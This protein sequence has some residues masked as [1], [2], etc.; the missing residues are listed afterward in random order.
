[1]ALQW[2]LSHLPY[3]RHGKDLLTY[4]HRD[5]SGRCVHTSPTGQEKVAGVQG[6]MGTEAGA[7]S[8]W[9]Q[10]TVALLSSRL[11]A[12]DRVCLVLAGFS[13]APT[14]D[15]SRL[16]KMQQ[17]RRVRICNTDYEHTDVSVTQIRVLLYFSTE[18]PNMV[19][20]LRTLNSNYIFCI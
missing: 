8:L 15:R 5:L 10:P 18:P 1:M 9:W 12:D 6:L 7:D 4:N 19:N 14:S 11:T 17:H 3:S 13:A 2:Y 16:F 20:H